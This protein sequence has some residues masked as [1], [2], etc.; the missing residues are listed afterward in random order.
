MIVLFVWH[1]WAHFAN[2]NEFMCILLCISVWVTHLS[3][4]HFTF[5]LLFLKHESE[6][7]SEKFAFSSRFGSKTDVPNAVNCW[8]KTSSKN[9]HSNV[10]NRKH[11]QHL[12]QPRPYH[13][14]PVHK[15]T[16]FPPS[17]KQFGSFWFSV[18]YLFLEVSKIRTALENEIKEKSPIYSSPSSRAPMKIT[19]NQMIMIAPS[20]PGSSAHDNNTGSGVWPTCHPPDAHSMASNPDSFS[21][22]R[23]ETTFPSNYSQN[24]PNYYT[25]VDYLS[26][27]THQTAV[28]SDFLYSKSSFRK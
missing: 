7:K 23:I 28:F 10:H 19:P 1:E 8:N 3:H 5:Q 27:S 13:L 26:L 2:Q 25:N 21:W 17:N 9:S 15:P 11:P 18:I 16:L 22:N 12:H 14:Q 6:I 24:L 20:Y 4:I